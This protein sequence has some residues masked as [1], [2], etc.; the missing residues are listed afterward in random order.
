MWISILIDNSF[1]KFPMTTIGAILAMLAT[2]TVVAAWDRRPKQR[3][4]LAKVSVHFLSLLVL[5]IVV[6]LASDFVLGLAGLD[7]QFEANESLKMDDPDVL[8][9]IL[10]MLGVVL[11]VVSE[12]V[13][14]AAWASRSLRNNCNRSDALAKE[15]F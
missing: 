11:F 14:V 7:A 3:G 9:V 15:L 13:N 1:A 8:C 6:P 12:V 5:V 4:L 2:T 10:M